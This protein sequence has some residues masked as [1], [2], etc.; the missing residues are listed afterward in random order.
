[1]S[2]RLM[3]LGWITT[4]SG[5]SSGR[6]KKTSRSKQMNS[7]S[8]ASSS[9]RFHWSSCRAWSPPIIQNNS[10]SGNSLAISSAVSIEKLVPPRSISNWRISNLGSASIARRVISARSFAVASGAFGLSGAWAAGMKRTRSSAICSAASDANIRCPMCIG[11]K[12]PPNMPIRSVLILSIE[13]RFTPVRFEMERTGSRVWKAPAFRAGR[14][15][16]G[17]SR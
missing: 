11:S 7:T 2:S 14:L 16:V 5:R 3:A 13:T 15:V 12:L 17:K 10:A 1:M 6:T 8:F 4:L 9:M